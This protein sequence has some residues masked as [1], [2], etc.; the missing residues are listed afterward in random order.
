MKANTCLIVGAG[1]A[2]LNAAR[3]LKAGGW[4]VTVIDKGRTV[5]GRLATRRVDDGVYDH[6]AQFITVRD[7][8]F[9][10]LISHLEREHVVY[11]WC[12]GIGSVDEPASEDGHP[13]YQGTGGM[14]QIAKFL[15]SGL[16][17]RVRHRAVQIQQLGKGWVA[18]LESGQV[19]SSDALILTTP[20]PQALDLLDLGGCEL[21][22]NSRKEL[23]GIKYHP[24]LAVLASF[25]KATTIPHPGALRFT[26]GPLAFLCDNRK[27][28]ISPDA[29]AVTLHAT[30]E[31]SREHWS[32]ADGDAV[33]VLLEAAKPWI[34]GPALTPLLHRWRYSMP[35]NPYPEHCLRVES[36]A[37]IVFAG[38]AFKGPRVEGAAL[39]GMA[40]A[41]SLLAS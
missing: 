6:G 16:D 15:A 30:P 12:R 11:E 10:S 13:R 17:V 7:P 31:F 29:T 1:M 18:M 27:K 37:P 41:E 34:P 32:V 23:N 22:E 28:G 2:G 24:C 36:P 3:M 19:I 39:S 21:S 35:I 40:A 33:S 26:S 20:V 5:G 38:D 14:N 9:A 25:E 8:R 4:Q